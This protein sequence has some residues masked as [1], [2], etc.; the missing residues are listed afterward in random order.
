VLDQKVDAKTAAL[1]QLKANPKVLDSWLAGVKTY[2]GEDGLAA[3]KKLLAQ[4]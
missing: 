4:N 1:H 2:G 3:V